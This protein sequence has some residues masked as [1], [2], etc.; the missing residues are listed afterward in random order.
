MKLEEAA[1]QPL[2]ERATPPPEPLCLPLEMAQ[3]QAQ[4]R[5]QSPQMCACATPPSDRQTTPR[6]LLQSPSTTAA[7]QPTFPVALACSPNHLTENW[8]TPPSELRPWRDQWRPYIKWAKFFL[9]SPAT[10][11]RPHSRAHFLQT[12]PCSPTWR[13]MP[14]QDILWRYTRLSP[15]SM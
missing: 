8:R 7:N 6:G 9:A 2:Q 1:L 11:T 12:Q 5:T 14:W 10:L 4:A 15:R 3:F 13:E